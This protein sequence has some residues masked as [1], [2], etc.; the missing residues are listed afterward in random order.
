[1]STIIDQYRI[2]K[3][4]YYHSVADEVKLYEAA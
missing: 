3:E 1:M 2:K 4:P